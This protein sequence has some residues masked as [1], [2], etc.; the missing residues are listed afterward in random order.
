MYGHLCQMDK[1]MKI[2]KK[3][4]L[5][6]IEDCSQS[7]G[8]MFKQIKCQQFGDFGCFSLFLQRTLGVK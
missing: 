8:A 2:A 1:I 7:H 3:F 6:V 5:K 4:K